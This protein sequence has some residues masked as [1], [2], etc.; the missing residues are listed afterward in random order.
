MC[1]KN[2]NFPSMTISHMT[3][4]LAFKRDR[5]SARTVHPVDQMRN[6]G[7]IDAAAKPERMIG[8]DRRRGR[9]TLLQTG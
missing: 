6:K 3:E 2:L 1:G 5:H 7:E 8:E 9:Y 4:C